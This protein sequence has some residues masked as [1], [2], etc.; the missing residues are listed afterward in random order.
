MK[1]T[2]LAATEQQA[3]DR[4]RFDRSHAALAYK[5]AF[6]L[7]FHR[8]VSF[9]LLNLHCNLQ[10]HPLEPQQTL[11]EMASILNQYKVGGTWLCPRVPP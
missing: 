10:S 2:P 11:N 4:H 5:A 3:V 9:S 6:S 1:A 8:F 7:A